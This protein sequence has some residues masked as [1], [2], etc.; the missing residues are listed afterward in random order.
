MSQK[1][2]FFKEIW[3]ML[4]KLLLILVFVLLVA[5]WYTERHSMAQPVA[6]LPVNQVVTPAKAPSSR[7]VIEA[8]RVS[9]GSQ[10]L[11]SIARTMLDSDWERSPCR[12]A[13]DMREDGKV[14]E[15]MVA[16][17]EGVTAANIRIN[18]IGNA[19]TLS[20]ADQ[21]GGQTLLRRVRLPC[22]LVRAEH[23]TSVISNN[24]LHVRILNPEA[25]E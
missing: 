14:Y 1:Y 20:V 11:N 4:D 2:K 17:P 25:R 8:Q 22:S 24:V 16:L 19:L 18:A 21:A 7:K 12:P 5:V 10:R 15:V 9:T 3:I 13:L 23:V 6:M